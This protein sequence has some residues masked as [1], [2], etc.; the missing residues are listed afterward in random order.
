MQLLPFWE[1]LER[2]GK[3]IINI[4]INIKFMKKRN[5]IILFI[6]LLIIFIALIIFL[7]KFNENK[8][9]LRTDK[10][11]IWA[12][13]DAI[14]YYFTND[15][16]F[17]YIFNYKKL[18]INPECL[19]G[20][21]T[22][23]YIEEKDIPK[24]RGVVESGYDYDTRFLE[25]EKKYIAKIGIDSCNDIYRFY[26]NNNGSSLPEIIARGNYESDQEFERAYDKKINDF[27]S[28]LKEYD[29]ECG[30]CLMK[31]LD[32][33]GVDHTPFHAFRD[34]EVNYQYLEEYYIKKYVDTGAE[35]ENRFL[36]PKKQIAVNF[37]DG[38]KIYNDRQI[39]FGPLSRNLG[40]DPQDESLV[41]HFDLEIEDY[42]EAKYVISNLKSYNKN[43]TIEPVI[44]K[45]GDFE[46]VKYAEGGMCEKRA[47][48]VIGKR[49][50][51]DF[52]SNGCVNDS[53]TDFDYLTKTIEQM[54]IIETEDFSL[55]T[56][57]VYEDENLHLR[58]KYY[59]SP[60]NKIL[61]K[62]V[63]NRVYFY[64][65]GYDYESGQYI[66]KFDKKIDLSL[67]EAIENDLLGAGTADYCFVETKYD[68]I[69]SQKAIIS[70][71]SDVACENDEPSWVCANCSSYR[72]QNGGATFIYYKNQPDVYF[73]ISIGQ[74]SLMTNID[75][76]SG[77]E[78]SKL[79]WFNNIEAIGSGLTSE[80]KDEWLSYYDKDYGIEFKHP[81]NILVDKG[82]NG[83]LFKMK[84]DSGYFWL[85]IIEN[86]DKKNALEIKNDYY[87]ND[88][89]G[90]QYEDSYLDIGGIRSY[91]Q[92]RYDLGVIENYFIPKGD[93]IIY[94]N[95]EFNFESA[96]DSA[97]NDKKEL[98]KDIL[99]TFKL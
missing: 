3:E 29:D 71:P 84:D 89:Y 81:Q 69:D 93:K 99:S 9:E 57:S 75:G 14:G 12:D 61:A 39:G 1:R 40:P 56:N 10:D 79:E 22:D 43:L 62:R 20:W 21:G 5:K 78:I 80:T 45:V 72:A 66:E 73:Y 35:N 11:V 18:I 31:I 63:G 51:Y 16:E 33:W 98:I 96:D 67:A 6:F 54:E 52:S 47:M 36:D 77:E 7:F 85:S 34:G 90:Y 48:K 15:G 19:D 88:A 23:Y 24:N 60:E 26:I 37:L 49:F 28:F 38:Y 55:S 13:K 17:K 8:I 83:T 68:S 50:N 87:K 41:H 82:G 95:F 74:A 59:S 4:K 30:G 92:G 91:K 44:L 32:G 25:E 42:R 70:F 2:V 27:N 86:P 94:F 53:E 97:K 46:V 64:P 58:I 65:D 76:L